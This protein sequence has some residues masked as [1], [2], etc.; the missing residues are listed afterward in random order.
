MLVEIIA[1]LGAVI[2]FAGEAVASVATPDHTI[3]GMADWPMFKFML[4]LLIGF[5][6]LFW[7]TTVSFVG[8]I[9]RDLKK[10]IAGQRKEDHERCGEC[11]TEIWKKLNE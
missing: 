11:K 9:W 7:I 8:Y 10:R 5:L 1:A 3:T 6:G 4:Q 2:M